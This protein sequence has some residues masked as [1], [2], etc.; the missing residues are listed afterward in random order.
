MSDLIQSRVATNVRYARTRAGLSQRQLA[1]GLGHTEKLSISRW[2]NGHVL[3]STANVIA[4]A[5][6]LGIDDPAWFYLDHSAE[7]AAAAA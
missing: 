7:A 2:E 1:D 3:P 4:L 6:L 5:E